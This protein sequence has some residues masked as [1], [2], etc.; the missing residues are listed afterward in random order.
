MHVITKVWYTHLG[1]ERT[2]VSV[3]ESLQ[4]LEPA[5]RSDKVDLKVHLLLHWP[6]CYDNIEWMNCAADEESLDVAIKNAGP[7]PR[8]DPENAWKESWKFLEDIYL[9]DE[10]P[11]ASI[12]LSN[13]HLEDIE[14]MDAFA[15]IQPHILQMNLWYLMYDSQLVDYCH[16]HRIHVQVYNAIQG[17]VG[18]PNRAPHAFHHI[19]KVANELGRQA[20]LPV[21]PSQTVLAWLIQH[22]ISVIPRTTK[23]SRLEENSAVILSTIPVFTDS[24]IET[25]AHAVEAFLS[26]TD[27]EKD[28]HVTVTFHAVNEDLMLYWVLGDDREMRIDHI[29]KG[30]KFEE[31]TYPGHMFRTYNAYN[32]D[33]YVEHTIDANFGE[34]KDI[35]VEL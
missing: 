22:G 24:Q 4:A 12:G 8:K 25:V 10:F 1:Y 13:F 5:L 7:D 15:R 19:Q 18:E 32:K 27:M 2:K 17:T 28:I 20:A 23:L 16:K 6:R 11:I 34:H 14:K 29:R 3:Q 9:S 33:I 26:G 35:H 21:T 30:D 31:T